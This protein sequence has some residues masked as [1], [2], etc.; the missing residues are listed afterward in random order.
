ME[1]FK[2]RKTAV[3]VNP[4]LCS[5]LSP[6]KSSLTI[7]CRWRVP[8]GVALRR[9]QWPL[10][11]EHN[12]ASQ[13]NTWHHNVRLPY[14]LLHVCLCIKLQWQG[15]D[16]GQ[17]C[18]ARASLHTTIHK[19]THTRTL[20][21]P[22]RSKWISWCLRRAQCCYIE[23]PGQA[24]GQTCS[25]Q[26]NCSLFRSPLERLC[27]FLFFSALIN[28]ISLPLIV[29]SLSLSGSDLGVNLAQKDFTSSDEEWKAAPAAAL[30]AAAF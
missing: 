14:T 25:T 26:D 16:K 22:L 13:E 15:R 4:P 5:L 9:T 23:G 12:T 6:P 18:S 10:I 2:K 3:T 27:N 29:V 28:A 30:I 11:W 8:D 17:R 7:L 21:I 19:H 24:S 1:A 20:F